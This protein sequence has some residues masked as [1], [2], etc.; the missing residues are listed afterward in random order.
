MFV[1]W[2]SICNT[3]FLPIQIN[4]VTHTTWKETIISSILE[5]ISTIK[6]GQWERLVNRPP[7]LTIFL[8]NKET[9]VKCLHWRGL[10]V[11]WSHLLTSLHLW[12]TE[13]PMTDEKKSNSF[14]N[15]SP[16]CSLAYFSSLCSQ[17]LWSKNI[18]PRAYISWEEDQ[19][20]GDS[21]T[22]EA[23][24]PDT[25]IKYKSERTLA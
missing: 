4:M 24:S 8:K 3:W 1:L 25:N 6:E 22:H 15:I 7:K 19:S 18:Q 14:R 12:L 21:V 17:N 11:L 2:N 20:R 9:K 13:I 16:L 23:C 10:L 5:Q